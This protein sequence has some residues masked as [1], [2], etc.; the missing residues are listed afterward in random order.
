MR[1]ALSR[2][3]LVALAG[4]LAGC[5]A[6]PAGGPPPRLLRLQPR[7]VFPDDL[8]RVMWALAVA[9]PWAERALDTDRVAVLTA[10]R[11]FAYLEGVRWTD[12]L[13]RL[14]QL[15]TVRAFLASDAVAAVATDRDPLRPHFLLRAVLEAFQLETGGEGGRRVRVSLMATLLRLPWRR[16]VASR[17]FAG[18][19]P[20]TGR[21]LAA[22]G[23]A[24]DAALAP[25]LARMVTWTL[26]RGEEDWRRTPPPSWPEGVPFPFP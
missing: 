8:P 1:R 9:E 14:F 2:R 10:G 5:V 18:E 23:G 6:L 22:I 3:T 13:P 4:T 12:R 20:V 17:R 7:P 16:A 15:L 24:F 25:L 26:A 19:A 11:E 21:D